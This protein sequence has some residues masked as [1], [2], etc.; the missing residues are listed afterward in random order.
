MTAP[1][2]QPLELP[3]KPRI[4]RYCVSI[5]TGNIDYGNVDEH[6]P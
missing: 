6:E 1:F 2:S 4:Q 3:A 5:L